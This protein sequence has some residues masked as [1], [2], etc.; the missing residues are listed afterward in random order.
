MA[1]VA[2]ADVANQSW[3]L[4]SQ[5]T[6]ELSS[7]STEEL[8]RLSWEVSDADLGVVRYGPF[9]LKSSPILR[10]AGLHAFLIHLLSRSDGALSLGAI[11]AVMRQRFNLWEFRTAEL[12][13]V[14]ASE[15]FADL[16]AVEDAD[17]ARSVVA[18]LGKDAGDALRAFHE[19]KS[20]REAGVRLRIPTARV[21]EHVCGAM[22][23]IADLA[24]TSEEGN[25]VYELVVESLFREE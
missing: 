6:R 16:S 14:V 15:E 23:L 21:R 2:G 25:R 13:D 19:T 1:V 12:A 9:S 3:T 24:D 10:A 11:A 20:L 4:R 22:R 8:V 18:R 5:P 17:L 7:S